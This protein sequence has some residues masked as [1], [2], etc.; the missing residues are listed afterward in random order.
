MSDLKLKFWDAK[1]KIWWDATDC[2][3]DGEGTVY[4]NGPG[5]IEH[6]EHITAVQFTGI[7][8]KN[9]KVIYEY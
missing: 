4:L 2:L 7:T 5:G 1:N 8:D 6:C 3:V 9:G